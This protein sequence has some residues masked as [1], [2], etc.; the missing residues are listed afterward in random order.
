MSWNPQ[1]EAQYVNSSGPYSSTGGFM[2]FFEGFTYE[3]MNFIFADAPY[4]Q[5]SA[6]PSVNTSSYKFG[7]S[8]PGTLSY[9]DYNHTYMVDDRAPEI[10]EYNIHLDNSSIV[11]DELMTAVRTRRDGHPSS[12]SHANPVDCPRS[13]HN[14]RDYQ[15]VW[16]DSID[17]DN[18]TY[19][20][21]LD[22]GEAVGTQSRGLSHEHISLLPVSKFKCGFFSRR[23]SKDERC[24]ICQ[25]EYK[26]GDRRMTLPCKHACPICY[27]EV[28]ADASKR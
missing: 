27:K 6:Y 20:E 9:Y 11:P 24:V 16:Q 21:L 28:L 14:S 1:L 13:Q 19:E 15:V 26:R 22:L 12:S 2:D 23:K 18:M 8:E 7:L 17:P 25:M 10:H 4:A 3:H 5:E